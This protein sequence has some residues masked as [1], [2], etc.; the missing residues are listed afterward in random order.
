M[1]E[2]GSLVRIFFSGWF[3]FDGDGSSEIL[4]SK[5]AANNQAYLLQ[6]TSTKK[7]T[8]N[9]SVDGSATTTV[10]ST[11]DIENTTWTFVAGRFDPSSTLSI[12]VNREKT[13]N[14]TSIPASI[15]ISGNAPFNISGYNNG[16]QLINGKASLCF[17]CGA[18][19]SDAQIFT[20]YEQTRILFNV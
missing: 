1:L 17:L 3:Y 6:R 10:T 12:F 18:Y 7:A 9:V 11:S 16:T 5:W 2:K 14:T 13:D 19:L 8:F 15:Y 4:L 20:L